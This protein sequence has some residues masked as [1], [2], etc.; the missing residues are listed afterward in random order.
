[1]QFSFS[2][3]GAAFKIMN[4]FM[5][6]VWHI[7]VRQA[8]LLSCIKRTFSSCAGVK[9]SPLLVGDLGLEVLL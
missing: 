3:Q 5:K 9:S 1:M 2:F 6:R 8:Y 4:V 7:I